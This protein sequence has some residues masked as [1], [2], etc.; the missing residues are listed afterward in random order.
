VKIIHRCVKSGGTRRR[1][2]HSTY[3]ASDR[4]VDHKLVPGTKLQLEPFVWNYIAQEKIT[5]QRRFEYEFDEFER[6]Y[7]FTNSLLLLT[8]L[9]GLATLR[10]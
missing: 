9:T 10:C 6:R 3:T 5:L 2:S 8:S 1:S 7:I 4:I